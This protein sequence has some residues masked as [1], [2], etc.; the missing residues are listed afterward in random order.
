MRDLTVDPR[1]LD[2]T[3]VELQ[4]R[5]QEFARVLTALKS[6]ARTLTG[7][8]EGRAQGAFVGA[9]TRWD[10]DIETYSR[11]L[12]EAAAAARDAAQ[13]YAEADS[14]VASLWQI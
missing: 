2:S 5:A 10:S 4:Q 3:A 8:W 12:F 14:A 7:R 13:A 6:E 1:R 11:T 9:Y